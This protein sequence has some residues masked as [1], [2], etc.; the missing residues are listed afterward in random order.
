MDIAVAEGKLRKFNS[1]GFQFNVMVALASFCDHRLNESSARVTTFLRKEAR[2]VSLLTSAPTFMESC[3][4]PHV[5]SYSFNGRNR[6]RMATL[7][8]VFE[9]LGS[10]GNRCH[11][12]TK[13][14][15]PMFTMARIRL[16]WTACYQTRSR[17]W[18]CRNWERP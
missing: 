1:A 7:H 6:D 12:N 4:L 17:G 9:I 5:S 2:F 16:T 13:G 15:K 11:Q 3:E 18:K 14:D 10:T 8:P